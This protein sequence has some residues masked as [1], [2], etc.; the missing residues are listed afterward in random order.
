MFSADVRVVSDHVDK[1]EIDEKG[2]IEFQIELTV[3]SNPELIQQ[4]V[5]QEQGSHE[6]R[7]EFTLEELL[8]DHD[9]KDHIDF[10]ISCRTHTF[11]IN[12]KKNLV[13]TANLRNVKFVLL[14]IGNGMKIRAIQTFDL[15]VF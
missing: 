6:N 13:E 12:C 11:R 15:L 9:S 3:D 8:A 7:C 5:L 2:F 4:V 1:K 10:N 14:A